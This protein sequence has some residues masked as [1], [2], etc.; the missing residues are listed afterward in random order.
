M[1][2]IPKSHRVTRAPEGMAVIPKGNARS[3][4]RKIL[5]VALVLCWTAAFGNSS[6]VD[7]E[8]DHN[9]TFYGPGGSWGLKGIGS[10]TLVAL[11]PRHFLVGLPIGAVA[12]APAVGAWAVYAL[13]WYLIRQKRT[14]A[15]SE[16]RDPK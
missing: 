5:T 16:S 14:H 15:D 6:M 1:G 11:G 4:A 7:F 13:L 2:M 12:A 9:W 8:W 3:A 10:S